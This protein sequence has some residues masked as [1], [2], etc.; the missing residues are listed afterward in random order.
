LVKIS[1]AGAKPTFFCPCLMAC[2]VCIATKL[3][4]NKLDEATRTINI[5]VDTIPAHKRT[6]KLKNE[7]NANMPPFNFSLLDFRK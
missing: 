6:L 1:D 5:T 2:Y 4:Y 3:I 7:G